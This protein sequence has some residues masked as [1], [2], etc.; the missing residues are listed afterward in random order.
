MDDE[1][2]EFFRHGKRL[3]ILTSLEFVKFF[4]GNA[5]PN[6]SRK[7]HI[8]LLPKEQSD[9][10]LT[11]FLQT[12]EYRE[13]NGI[14]RNDFVSLLLGL[15]DFYTPTELAG[16]SFIVFLGGSE[17]SSILITFACYELALN[18]EIQKRLRDEI[19]AG[20]NENDGKLT[21]EMLFGFKYLDMVINES[22]RKYPPIPAATRKCTTEYKIPGTDLIIP[23]GVQIQLPVYSLHRDPEHYPE[24]EKFD[25]ERFNAENSKNRNPF[26]FLPFAEGK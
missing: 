22:L 4:F 15:K 12:I 5:F 11:N 1:N 18:P 21:Y 24:P 14:V 8:S 10:F 9:F 26:T 25:P 19:K 16:E 6:L 20:L 23:K 17:T 2:S 7:L 13:K 3:S